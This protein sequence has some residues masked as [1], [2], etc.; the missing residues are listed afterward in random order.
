[1]QHGG[2]KANLVLFTHL[3]CGTFVANPVNT[4]R[5]S[6]CVV[7]AYG[8]EIRQSRAENRSLELFITLSLLKIKKLFE[9]IRHAT[10]AVISP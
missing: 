7:D 5:L 4:S 3:A 6:F 1:M 2:R 10:L 9:E 8:S